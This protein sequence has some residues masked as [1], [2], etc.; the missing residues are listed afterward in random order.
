MLLFNSK[1]KTGKRR[2][3]S[4]INMFC[5]LDKTDNHFVT[6]DENNN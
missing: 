5:K 6:I 4:L 1:H 2:I 3:L